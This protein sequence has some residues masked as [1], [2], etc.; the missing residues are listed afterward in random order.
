[1]DALATAVASNP[2]YYIGCLLALGA[3]VGVLYFT[4]G[5]SLGVKNLITLSEESHHV[6]HAHTHGLQGLYLVMVVFGI[7]EI[8]RVIFI[9]G[10]ASLWVLIFIL[11]TPLWIPWLKRLFTGGGGH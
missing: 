9:G 2:L 3:V 4:Q 1:M 6:E 8:L 7:W 11:L 5:I 10:D